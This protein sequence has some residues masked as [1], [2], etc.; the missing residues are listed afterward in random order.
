MLA[1]A[2]PS[3]LVAGGLALVAGSCPV[4]AGA[5]CVSAVE[6]AVAAGVASLED[7]AGTNSLLLVTLSELFEALW[8][9]WLL[10]GLA[11]DATR[12]AG[13][14]SVLRVLATWLVVGAVGATAGGAAGGTLAGV[15]V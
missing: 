8:P 1:A 4:C 9:E 5:C 6:L 13:A 14:S 12:V 15:A 7:G 3:L 11:A 10:F 2:G